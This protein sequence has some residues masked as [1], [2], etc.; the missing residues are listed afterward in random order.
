MHP[1][2]Q[3]KN[4]QASSA[5]RLPSG[6][7]FA[8]VCPAS[9]WYQNTTSAGTGQGLSCALSPLGETLIHLGGRARRCTHVRVLAW[10]LLVAG[11]C[12]S[13][14][15][16]LLTVLPLPQIWHHELGH[17]EHCTLSSLQGS[18]TPLPLPHHGR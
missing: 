15:T 18:P 3:R 8:L 10:G 2:A 6:S 4:P 16:A 14:P 17:S 13:G 5:L 11:S 9:T 12:L 1:R 7:S